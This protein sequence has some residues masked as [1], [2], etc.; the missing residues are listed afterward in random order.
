[1]GSPEPS[2]PE[3]RRLKM[4]DLEDATGVGREAIRFYIREGLLP[5]PERPAKNVAWYDE[6]F[7]AQIRLIKKLQEKRYLPLRVIR[8]IV[9]ED[10]GLSADEVEALL[11][12]D[13]KLVPQR[14]S[15]TR[16]G[17]ESVSSASKRHDMNTDD[18]RTMA[19]LG[20]IELTSRDGE[21]W[22]EPQSLAIVEKWADF[23]SAG[24]TPE[25]GFPVEYVG[26]YV[27][28]VDWLAR[29]E[30]RLFSRGVT[31]KVTGQAAVD[32]AEQ[33]IELGDQLVGLLRRKTILRLIAEGDVGAQPERPRRGQAGLAR[34][35][36]ERRTSRKS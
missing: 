4:K 5:E 13:G 35:A 1:M 18:I 29:E 25:A 16:P 34:R 22:L 10:D 26:L 11:D 24:F 3:P 36:F 6:S 19:D 28:M 15:A 30:L 14:G 2:G 27:D 31:G 12:L 17:G 33:G 21:D 20:A 7:V 8:R 23:R 32:L 9:A